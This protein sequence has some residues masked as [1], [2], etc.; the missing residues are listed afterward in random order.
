MHPQVLRE[1]VD[2]NE[3]PRNCLWKIVATG[4]GSWG[5]RE[6]HCHSYFQGEGF[7]EHCSSKL[8]SKSLFWHMQQT[9]KHR[10]R[11][12]A[13]W[14]LGKESSISSRG[15]VWGTLHTQTLPPDFLQMPKDLR[16]RSWFYLVPC[17]L[18]TFLSLITSLPALWEC[19]RAWRSKAWS[20]SKATH[21][22]LPTPVMG[23]QREGECLGKELNIQT[24]Q[25]KHLSS[26][27]LCMWSKPATFR[28]NGFMQI[29]RPCGTHHT[30]HAGL[31]AK[32]C[33]RDVLP[34]RSWALCACAGQLRAA[35]TGDTSERL[36]NLAAGCLQTCRTCCVEPRH[37]IF[38]GK[39]FKVLLSTYPGLHPCILTYCSA[40]KEKRVIL[41][42]SEI[43]I[44]TAHY[45]N[46]ACWK[47]L[48]TQPS[49][50]N[51]E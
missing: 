20:W 27:L 29:T 32:A 49:A 31:C 14:M 4:E 43:L 16:R 38:W 1:L 12:E 40:Q 19:T 15:F 51:E 47:C 24:T 13:P 9:K 5:L 18:H 44:T 35:C 37:W 41:K 22:Y 48:S 36:P 33:T 7:S 21:F 50:P 2:I 26:E 28:L 8:C 11:S 23:T 25:W 42:P 34:T 46:V 17:Q 3:R 30:G 6:S 39:V 10:A 45:T